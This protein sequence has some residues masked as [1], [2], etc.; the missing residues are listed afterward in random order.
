[1]KP[2]ATTSTKASD[3]F[4]VGG[5]LVT[6][7]Y[8]L[9]PSDIAQ[10]LL[11]AGL[12][13]AA[14]VGLVSGVRR[15][16]PHATWAW[17][18]L[19]LGWM[20]YS[21][22]NFVWY[23]YQVVA[24]V[25]L[26]YPNPSDALFIAGYILLL[27]GL[28]GL[29]RNRT[30]GRDPG[31][32]VDSAI[33][34]IGVG[35]LSW[36]FLIAPYLAD[37]RLTLDA[38]LASIAYPT[39]DAT[40][41]ALLALF[42]FTPGSRPR[43]FWFLAAGLVGQLVADLYLSL[44]VL[45]GTFRFGEAYFVGYLTFYVLFGAAVL[46]PSMRELSEPQVGREPQLSR[47]RLAFLAA[48]ALLPLFVI[49]LHDLLAVDPLGAGERS[50]YLG[51]T[52]V[53]FLLVLLR[54]AKLLVD[55]AEYR[56]MERLKD[57]FVSVVS[58]ELRTPLT[59][60]RGALGLVAG[61]AMGELPGGAKRMVDIAAQNAD[62]LVR[63]V[64]DILDIERMESGRVSM[65]LRRCSVEDLLE[66]A[67]VEMKPMADAAGVELSKQVSEAVA[68]ADPDRIVQT[69]TNLLSN[70]IK[71]SNAGGQ[72]RIQTQSVDGKVRV[73]ISDEGRGIPPEHQAR[74]FDR[75]QQVD[76]SDARDK[77]GTGLG[78]AICKS[79]VERHGGRIWVESEPGR[80]STFFFTL[81]AVEEVGAVQGTRGPRV[82]VCD[83]DPSVLE[84]V[85]T[86]LAK[87][88]YTPIPAAGGREAVD[89][90]V[91][92][93]PDIVL[94]DLLMPGMDGCAT[95]RELQTFE[96]TRD[97]PVVILS[98]LMRGEGGVPASDIAG[99][100]NKPLDH[101]A[102]FGALEDALRSRRE[103]TS[104]LI[105]EPDLELAEVLAEALRSEGVASY[106]A[107]SVRTGVELA[108][109]LKPDLIALA[110]LLPDGDGGEVVEALRD[111]NALRTT[112]LVIYTVKDLDHAERERLRL[113][114]TEFLTKGR[115]GV[116]GFCSSVTG[117]LNDRGAERTDVGV[118]R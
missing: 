76:A 64:N 59:S 114:P 106:H 58:H 71:F 5:G 79:I 25:I 92:E 7:V 70:A 47:W 46:D 20:L 3:A 53:M 61:G 77:G 86:M 55:I 111:D 109:A 87:Q 91:A 97:I 63:L 78:L 75:F 48:A 74:I 82:L 16:R 44:S 1:M 50:G 102:L 51:A 19:G 93:K 27:A 26:P 37:P 80:G 96:Q 18:I 56:R 115:V 117:L 101:D 35:V 39:L 99:W 34:G 88:G 105:V 72:V 60:I 68:I 84:V 12:H 83:D 116:E 110:L 52:A 10:S 11:F 57:E 42:V 107:S 73:A 17:V 54:M 28:A 9:I 103:G 4:L 81:P 113:G 36:E 15:Y 49:G 40:I 29:I 41:V 30:I 67:L 104:V 45:A 14:L 31:S 6:V 13:V 112:P 65:E 62:R 69:A 98:V 94:L 118:S 2:M 21:A 100:V 85:S 8:F 24:D 23:V 66:R 108:R 38:K 43:A 89:K 90:A 32:V 22:G 95:L 33:V